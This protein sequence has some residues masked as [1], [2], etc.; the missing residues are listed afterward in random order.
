MAVKLLS[1]SSG[2]KQNGNGFG[3]SGIRVADIVSNG[4]FKVDSQWTVRYWNKAAEKILGFT[5]KS[6]VGMN[7]W[8]AFTGRLP[9]EFY[10]AYRNKPLQDIPAHFEEYWPEMGSWF[11]VITYFFDDTLS[12]SFKSHSQ[13]AHS[14][15]ADHP[16]Q[17]LKVLNELYRFVTE[18]T[19]DCLWEW[20]LQNKEMFW[21][22]GGHKR[23]FGYPIENTL[24]PQSFW[25]EL[26]HPDDKERIWKK[27]GEVLAGH[28]DSWEIEYRFK[29]ADGT[30]ACV[31]DRAHIFYDDK[32]SAASM[33]G[34]TQDITARKSA[35]IQLL[36]ERLSKQRE[37]TEAV[38]NAHEN[39]RAAIGKELHDNLNQILGAAKLYIEMAKTDEEVREM[40]LDRSSGY[41]MK[42][43]EEIRKISKTLASPSV[44]LMG[45]IE[46]IRN[47]IDDLVVVYP[48]RIEF[49]E[50]GI[51]EKELEERLQLDILRIVQ[52]QL[53]NVIKH[54]NATLAIIHLN[55]RENEIILVI[56]DNGEGCDTSIEKSG[57]GL[58]NIR[59]RAESNH[60]WVTIASRPGD[61]YLLKVILHLAGIA[62]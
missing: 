55:R 18:V 15:H 26:L 45:L 19:N 9:K 62:K 21:I 5:A 44:H 33:I 46:S 54:A 50:S 58:I 42:V 47:V 39:E 29:K 61:G 7:I 41:I 34:A 36:E 20:D 14:K 57:V 16:E 35:D 10:T 22:D 43:I 56:S 28:G 32:N 51:V 27:L 30:Y 31:Q 17:Q 13:S 59:S 8:D 49:H 4:F 48:I 2:V 23:V 6:I 11:D 52:E 25:E 60:G 37:I 12:V 40:C 38:L 53:N 24:V 1:N 3:Y